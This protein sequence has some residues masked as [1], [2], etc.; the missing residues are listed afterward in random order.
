MQPERTLL[1]TASDI[2]VTA[3]KGAVSLPQAFVGL[4]DIP[5]GGR[6]GKGLGRL[7]YKPGETQ[8]IL[9]EWLSPA[10]QYA[11]RKV[12]EAEGFIP[13]LKAAVQNPST[14]ARAV[15]ESA[16]LMLGGAG[17][18]RGILSKAPGMLSR[19][20]SVSGL[21]A[22][23][24]AGAIGEGAIGA[25]A[26]AEAIREQTEDGLLTAKQSAAALGGGVG[27]ALFSAA[28]G[29]LAQKLGL[30]DVD[31]LLAGGRFKKPEQ[32]AKSIVAGGISE[33]LFEEMPQEMQETVWQNA[34]TGRPLLEGAAEAGAQALLTGVAMGSGANIIT[35]AAGQEQDT[36]RDEVPDQQRAQTQAPEPETEPQ[37][38]QAMFDMVADGLNTGQVDPADQDKAGMVSQLRGQLDEVRNHPDPEVRKVAEQNLDILEQMGVVEKP[39]EPAEPAEAGLA[40]EPEVTGTTDDFAAKPGEQQFDE[41]AAIARAQAIQPK[42]RTREE[43]KLIEQA[44]GETE[45]E[46]FT[47]RRARALP[48]NLRTPD[49]REI[50]KTAEQREQEGYAKEKLET[51]QAEAA[52]EKTAAGQQLSDAKISDL[53]GVVD[54]ENTSIN[55]LMGTVDRVRNTP[56]DQ[57]TEQDRKI[58]EIVGTGQSQEQKGAIV[59]PETGFREP[60]GELQATGEPQIR[61]RQIRKKAT[62]LADT[63]PAHRSMTEAIRQGGINI[64]VAKR[65]GWDIDSL[66]DIRRPGLFSKDAVM[67]PDEMAKTLGYETEEAMKNEWAK[68]P[69][70]KELKADAEAEYTGQDL[71]IEESV[72]SLEKEGFDLGSEEKVNVGNLLPGDEIVVADRRGVPDKLTH[73][74]YDKE[75][76][77]LLQDGELIKADPFE[78]IKILAK[79]TGDTATSEAVQERFSEIL[80]T[81]DPEKVKAFAAAL[82]G[83]VKV[84]P[85]LKPYQDVIEG[86][87]NR[88]LEALTGEEPQIKTESRKDTEGLQV[89]DSGQGGKGIDESRVVAGDKREGG[90]RELLEPIT[91][92]EDTPQLDTEKRTRYLGEQE[93]KDA[94]TESKRRQIGEAKKFQEERRDPKKQTPITEQR[95]YKDKLPKNT[96]RLMNVAADH[97]RAFNDAQASVNENLEHLEKLFE[98]AGTNQITVSYGG[99]EFTV[100]KPERGE[101][102]PIANRAGR[103]ALDALKQKYKDAGLLEYGRYNEKGVFIPGDFGKKGKLT[104]QP[105]GPKKSSAAAYGPKTLDAAAKEH[106]KFQRKLLLE[107]FKKDAA[108]KKIKET[109]VTELDD[110]GF[111]HVWSNT[112]KDTVFFIT[113]P[114]GVSKFSSEDVKKDYSAERKEAQEAPQHVKR[115]VRKLGTAGRGATE[116]KALGLKKGEKAERQ[117][118]AEAELD[119]ILK[120]VSGAPL[121]KGQRADIMG[122]LTK[123]LGRSVLTQQKRGVFEVVS[124]KRAAQILSNAPYI[125]KSTGPVAT[126]LTVTHNLSE[127]SLVFADKF[128]GL[129]VPSIAVTPSDVYTDSRFGSIAL[130]GTYDLADPSFNPVFD[131]DAYTARFPSPEYAPLRDR[132]IDLI[133][134][135][136]DKIMMDWGVDIDYDIRSASKRGDAEKVIELLLRSSAVKAAYLKEQGVSVN[137]VMKQV[138]LGPHAYLVTDPGVRRVLRKHKRL[139]VHELIDNNEALADLSAAAKKPI[140]ERFE[141]RSPLLKKAAGRMVDEE[142]GLLSRKVVESIFLNKDKVGVKKVDFLA[143]EK[144]VNAKL[145][146]K[147][148]AAFKGVIEGRVAEI[149]G[150]PYITVGR[151]KL[152]YNIDSVVQKIKS[153]GVKGEEST[154]T[155]SLGKARAMN[156]TKM[157]NL[158]MMRDRA[159]AQVRSPGTV[160]EENAITDEVVREY[161]EAIAEFSTAESHDGSIDYFQANDD[162]MSALANYIGSGGRDM[163][164][165]LKRFNFEGFSSSITKKAIEAANRMVTSPV[166]YFEAKPQRAVK[167]SEFPGAIIPKGTSKQVKDLLRR[168]GVKFGLYDPAVEGHYEEV[169][170]R[171]RKTLKNKGVEVLFSKNGRLEGLYDKNTG[172]SYL[173]QGHVESG[174]SLGV[175]AHEL[176]V[177]ARNLGFK[178]SKAFGTILKRVEFLAKKG[179]NQEVADAWGRAE[180]ANTPADQ[181]AEETLGY[182]M[183]NAPQHGIIRRL[184]N[185]LKRFLI[186]N[187]KFSEFFI[188]RLTPADLQAM[189]QSAIRADVG[190]QTRAAEGVNEF[191]QSVKMSTAKAADKI[192]GMAKFKRWAGNSTIIDDSERHQWGKGGTGQS[193]TVLVKHGTNQ[194]FTKFKLGLKGQDVKGATSESGFWFTDSQEEAQQ[195]AD[196]SA[197]RNVANAEEHEDKID[198]LL[199]RIEIA[200]DRGDFD[201]SEKLSEELEVLETEA[202]RGAGSG[203]LVMDVFVKMKNPLVFES[204]DFFD[205]TT[206][207]NEAIEKGHDGVVFYNISDSPKGGLTTNQFIVFNPT[208]IKSIHNTGEWSA[209]DPDIMKSYAG[210]RAETANVKT[211]AEAKKM[212]E[213]GQDNETIRQA[214]GWFRG[215]DKKW[216]FEID[217]SRSTFSMP[218][219]RM[220][221]LGD[222][223]K[224]DALYAA[225]P[226][227]K[228]LSVELK[229]DLK[230]A[231]GKYWPVGKY[232]RASMQILGGSQSTELKERVASLAKLEAL[233]VPT[234]LDEQAV[235]YFERKR[236]ESI[237]TARGEIAALESGESINE[238]IKDAVL[239]ELQHAIQDIEVFSMGGAP[240][241]FNQQR[242]AEDTWEAMVWAKQARKEYKKIPN[243][244]KRTADSILVQDHIEFDLQ[245][246]IPSENVRNMALQ[247]SF[248]FPEKHKK[249]HEENLAIVKLYGADRSPTAKSG[250]ELYKRLA[251]EVEARDTAARRKMTAEQRKSTKPYE[252]QGIAEEGMIVRFGEGVMMSMSAPAQEARRNTENLNATKD[253]KTSTTSVEAGNK[254]IRSIMETLRKIG[255]QTEEELG[256]SKAKEQKLLNQYR[257][258]LNDQSMSIDESVNLL[259]GL[260]RQAD[261]P[262]GAKQKIGQLV[263]QVTSAKRPE[264][265]RKRLNIALEKLESDI[266]RRLK[267]QIRT[268]VKRAAGPKRKGVIKRGRY[269]HEQ[270]KDITAIRE[271]V[272]NISGRQ[273]T[274]AITRIE[275]RLDK[276]HERL[277]GAEPEDA[278]TIRNQ[279]TDAEL[280]LHHLRTF[281]G[282]NGKGLNELL[283]AKYQIEE[284]RKLGRSKIRAVKEAWQSDIDKKTDWLV[285]EITGQDDPRPETV[286]QKNRRKQKEKSLIGKAKG[287][288]AA[289]ENSIQSFEHLLDRIT[290]KSGKKIFQSR[291]VKELGSMAH[292]ATR[293]VERYNREA[294]DQM[295]AKGL[296]IFGVKKGSTLTKRLQKLAKRTGQ[297]KVAGDTLQLSPM[298]AAYFYNVR[299]D[300]GSEKLFKK[301]GFTSETW[302]G[303]DDLMPKELKA[304]AEY[305][306]DDLLTEVLKGETEAYRA[307]NGVDR[308]PAGLFREGQTEIPVMNLNS[309]IMNR[310]FDANHYRAWAVPSKTFNDLF[311]VPETRGYIEQ[312]AGTSTLKALDKFLEDFSKSPREL[313]G[314]QAWMDK[315]RSNVVMSM[316]GANPTT[317]FKQL[318][319]IPAY[320]A[321]IPTAAFV[322]NFA[323]GLANFG[324]VRRMINDSA[325]A[326]ERFWSGYDRDIHEASKATAEQV[327][328][329]K[330]TRMRDV[331]MSMTKLGDQVA[332]YAGYTVYKYHYDKNVNQK[333]R[334]E[335]HRIGIEEFEKATERTQQAAG[336]KDMGSFQRGSSLQKLFTMYMTSPASYT[337]QTMAA[338]RHFPSD[339]VGSS[340]RLL[341]FNVMLPMMF[342]AVAS[343]LM[344]GSPG[345]EE[346]DEFWKKELRSVALGPFLGVPIARDIAVGVYESAM[347]QWYGSDVSYSPVTETGKSLTQAVFQ[348]SKGLRE[349]DDEAI[350]RAKRD[351]LDFIGYLSGIPMK[352]GR[353]LAEGVQDVI[354]EDTEHP[355]MAAAGY[356]R[357]ARNERYL[358]E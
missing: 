6:V 99:Q 63:H 198:G 250:L 347:G 51:R 105:S 47:I 305:L 264:T 129:A 256:K 20:A 152:P 4:A 153:S 222:I 357:A 70:K 89:D 304:W 65:E 274:E 56:A 239:H 79:K 295:L 80:E 113:R 291:A 311:S 228:N 355:F 55:E 26:L 281:G 164:Q 308:V 28:G 147:K 62:E 285:K 209:T 40:A 53:S 73:K 317:F 205:Q 233:E 200:E 231:F 224:H 183:N 313:R 279:I 219:G 35:S 100:K 132:D 207:I 49:E 298:E 107:R 175:L 34:A 350:S 23:A 246:L 140:R 310:I 309:A 346:W 117:A 220:S 216:R 101:E 287:A 286:A 248:F 329:G 302:S 42:D 96:E 137:P 185:S 273:A 114:T 259:N 68:A 335:A 352:P 320:A 187:G 148:A 32:V 22:E 1:E 312:H 74:G 334:K 319:S 253:G 29:R 37:A 169:T 110:Y 166:P 8:E 90:R 133:T 91:E 270:E 92:K 282:L 7:G 325:M 330:A 24:L 336:V 170:D 356:S 297:V 10:Q 299:K 194:N 332:V 179:E 130:I 230:G 331:L 353:R 108:H 94:P 272:H 192:K 103:D 111:D 182:L 81:T 30:D 294:T 327:I 106:I 337:R 288:Y 229:D 348:A 121:P 268:Q 155:V 19:L 324:A 11:E 161:R 276:L 261:I 263:K 97:Q 33:G 27:T 14:I 151:K 124:P 217:D 316:I 318:T 104:I 162:A 191:A 354:S 18:A 119:Q 12:Q 48:D 358:N 176:G 258:L 127:E 145:K 251:G 116:A 218:K 102:R 84:D 349:F 300:L 277:Q 267:A 193:I 204:S 257:Q 343:G 67:G 86:A 87:I 76:N 306:H 64:N 275:N 203:Q 158:E 31:T 82:P 243:P 214:T 17:I 181:M 344:M 135:P 21:S 177:H 125:R 223:L 46:E 340:K 57:L 88:R 321:D 245:E 154:M 196:Y 38:A 157:R 85:K 284:L 9:S 77:A 249:A 5:T 326:Q 199:D 178:N 98:K 136:Y 39:A 212:Q 58:A 160:K 25:G 341:L 180:A 292:S 206:I 95:N 128:G 210:E 165:S 237:A 338:L 186:N 242:K 60:Q 83:E 315:L 150:A 289:V 2:G 184:W 159:V 221:K 202:I 255:K 323:H 190:I 143:T 240:E 15:G 244:T 52:Q 142:T 43:A 122:E 293:G 112:K 225:Y 173:V 213:A 118:Q 78:E 188:N 314:D 61:E 41:E 280:R 172:K 328:G 168:Q 54:L 215:P 271:I 50:V 269:W 16:P 36:V 141:G 146:G 126:P 163:S 260:V 45:A 174:Q 69:T 189:A 232:S 139:K 238:N 123:Q 234:G 131:A 138:E 252:S 226:E 66:K 345:D 115:R 227:L 235:E 342:Q 201:L 278:E 149:F 265:Q 208:Q 44:K 333:G 93:T 254:A 236:S 197:E 72:S 283:E 109:V 156:A 167:L 59:A 296:E 211:L 290:I 262:A 303:L 3:L 301:M 134:G 171:I 75:G 247:D 339:P 307:V 120:S 195:Y 13:T 351:F 266:S 241:E 71:A 322:K 144:R